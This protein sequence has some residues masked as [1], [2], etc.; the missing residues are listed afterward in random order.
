MAA[1]MMMMPM[2]SDTALAADCSFRGKR[3]THGEFSSIQH[4]DTGQEENTEDSQCRHV[5]RRL[6]QDEY[7]DSAYHSKPPTPDSEVTHWEMV[8]AGRVGNWM[9]VLPTDK[10]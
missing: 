1:T 10:Y 7:Q 8:T 2:T 4:E 9:G 6:A 3:A 5:Y